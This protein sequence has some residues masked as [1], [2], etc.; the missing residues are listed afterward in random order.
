MWRV[1]AATGMGQRRL[2]R[3]P[4]INCGGLDLSGSEGWFVSLVTEGGRGLSLG[5]TSIYTSIFQNHS[6][7]KILMARDSNKFS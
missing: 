1:N 2:V 6:E 7:R 4:S 3:S 5:S